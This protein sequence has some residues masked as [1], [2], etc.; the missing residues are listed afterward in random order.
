VSQ[1]EDNAERAEAFLRVYAKMLR[2]YLTA[3]G[4]AADLADETVTDT[5]LV[6]QHKWK[7]VETLDN[8]A[9]W[10]RRVAWH[11]AIK[12]Q[13]RRHDW[14]SRHSVLTEAV[15]EGEDSIL[16][17]ANRDQLRR[18]IRNLPEKQRMAII[19]RYYGQFSVAEAAES[20]G[21]SPGTIMSNTSDGLRN[22]RRLLDEG[23]VLGEEER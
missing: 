19:L 7:H 5:F 2:R 22:L 15:S 12:K 1:H 20:L 13:Q 14:E 9:A 18:A 8:P 11:I 21:V 10:I 6:M 3:R 16:H 17:I 23:D 4:I